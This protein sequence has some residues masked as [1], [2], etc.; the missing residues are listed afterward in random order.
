MTD[1]ELFH[2]DAPETAPAAGLNLSADRR[3]TIRQAAMLAAGKHPLSAIL[4]RPLALHPDAAPADDRE[5]SGLRC[6]DCRYRRVIG[7][8]NRSYP[9]CLI[10]MGP[11]YYSAPRFSNGAASDCRAWWPAC[12]DWAPATAWKPVPGYKGRYEVSD[13]GQIRS[14]RRKGAPGGLLKASPDCLGYPSVSLCKPG[15]QQTARVHTLVL[16]AF[17]G[18]KPAGMEARHLDGDRTNNRLSNLVWGTH[19]EN[20]EDQVAHGTHPH[21]SKT[22]CPQGHPYDVANTYLHP[23]GDRRCRTCRSS[24]YQP[25]EAE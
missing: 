8:H 9:K 21:A 6:G 2:V 18:P 13:D 11:S 19:S 25:K 24:D 22:H 23:A 3:R 1:F 16:S 7:H 12:R 5:A 20:L 4:S 14:G 10:G 15:G 17:V